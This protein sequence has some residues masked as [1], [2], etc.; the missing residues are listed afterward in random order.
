MVFF[1]TFSYVYQSVTHVKALKPMKS[2]WEISRIF[3]RGEFNCSCVGI[4]KCLPAYCNAEKPNASVYDIPVKDFVEV[5][6]LKY[7]GEQIFGPWLPC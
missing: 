4:S 2:P 1:Q 3:L 7:L 5:H 6:C